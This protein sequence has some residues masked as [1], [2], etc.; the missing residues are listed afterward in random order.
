MNPLLHE[1]SNIP[2]DKVR[3]E[4]IGPA[5]TELLKSAR[6]NLDAVAAS[7]VTRDGVLLG[8]D[9][10]TGPLEFALGLAGHLE[11]VAGTPEHRAAWAKVQPEVATFYSGILTS[12]PLYRALVRYSKT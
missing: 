10:A 11:S 9:Q 6:A 3:P 7:P 8:F 1:T 5:V 4:H 12:E 2:F